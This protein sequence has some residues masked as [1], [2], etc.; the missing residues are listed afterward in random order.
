MTNAVADS[1]SPSEAPLRV[2]VASTVY[3]FED[4]VT[5]I[6]A[7]LSGYGYE[8]WNSHLGTIPTHPAKSNLDVC[9]D[10]VRHCDVF[11][12]VVR[13]FYGSGKVGER[14]ITHEEMR[15]AVAL[16]KPRW[17]L[18]HGHVTF[19]RQLLRP[20]RYRRDGKK[21]AKPFKL[22]KTSVMDDVRVLDMYD[23]VIQTGVP[24]SERKGHWAQEFYDLGAALTY[25][26]TQ[27]RDVA[28]I[29]EIVAEMTTS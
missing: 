2:M 12:G 27:L 4:G 9:L 20:L 18:V 19:A 29:R 22:V 10:A 24:V 14:S 21:R 1:S 17:F 16:R 7:V 11:L 26:D 23:D 6:C 8:V 5:Q 3:G 25:V 28:R 13:P 15:L